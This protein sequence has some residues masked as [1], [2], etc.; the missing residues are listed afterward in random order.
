MIGWSMPNSSQSAVRIIHS[1]SQ[2]KGVA[3][4]NY[5]GLGAHP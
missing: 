5:V 3:V 1:S 2:K 4:G